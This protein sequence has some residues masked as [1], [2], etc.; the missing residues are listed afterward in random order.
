MPIVTNSPSNQPL[1]PK[2]FLTPT[3]RSVAVSN[4]PGMQ[5]QRIAE[6]LRSAAVE[7]NIAMTLLPGLLVASG[8][9]ECDTLVLEGVD[10]QVLYGISISDPACPLEEGQLGVGLGNVVT[11]RLEPTRIGPMI[12]GEYR[13]ISLEGDAFFKVVAAVVKDCDPQQITNLE[14]SDLRNELADRVLLDDPLMSRIWA[15]AHPSVEDTAN[16]VSMLWRGGVVAATAAT[17]GVFGS[18]APMLLGAWYLGLPLA[19]TLHLAEQG[20]RESREHL[21]LHLARQLPGLD[22]SHLDILLRK[23]H[24][25]MAELD[26]ETV[27]VNLKRMFEEREPWQT[28]TDLLEH[29]RPADWLRAVRTNK[30]RQPVLTP[31][32][33]LLGGAIELAVYLNVPGL[34]PGQMYKAGSVPPIPPD[35]QLTF[36]ESEVKPSSAAPTAEEVAPTSSTSVDFMLPVVAAVV[37]AQGPSGGWGSGL[38]AGMLLV[39]SSVQAAPVGQ[40][41]LANI[42]AVQESVAEQ[43]TE[44]SRLKAQRR[45]LV[46]QK[47]VYEAALQKATGEL[48]LPPGSYPGF[49]SEKHYY[50]LLIRGNYQ[51]R[52]AM[53]FKIST[54]QDR[55][56]VLK[57]ALTQAINAADDVDRPSLTSSA[58]PSSPALGSDEYVDEV[59]LNQLRIHNNSGLAFDRKVLDEQVSVK[60]ATKG[61]SFSNAF[62]GDLTRYSVRDILLGKH[63]RCG[64]VVANV[65]PGDRLKHH[66][67]AAFLRR[68]EFAGYVAKQF[69][70]DTAALKKDPLYGEQYEHVARQRFQGVL[71]KYL[72][73]GASGHVRYLINQWMLGQT[74]ERLV[75]VNGKVVPHLLALWATAG[76]MLVSTATGKVYLWPEYDQSTE[77]ERFIR[78]HLSHVDQQ[79]IK[80]EDIIAQRSSIKDAQ[81]WTAKISFE[82]RHNPYARLFTAEMDWLDSN[83]NGYVFTADE[84]RQ[85]AEINLERGLMQ[86]GATVATLALTLGAGGELLPLVIALGVD[87]AT[88]VAS[89][90]LDY[91][92]LEVADSADLIREAEADISADRL[93]LIL[94]GASAGM[95]AVRPFMESVEMVGALT[96]DMKQIVRLFRQQLQSQNGER[97]SLAAF[98]RASPRERSIMMAE[99]GF[100][101]A[102]GQH[103]PAWQQVMHVQSRAGIPAS[104]SV[105]GSMAPD[106]RV[107]FLGR[108]AKQIFTAEDL[109]ALPRG[110]RVAVVA[111]SDGELLHGSVSL[112]NGKVTGLAQQTL[113]AKTSARPWTAVDLK[114]QLKFGPDGIHCNGAGVLVYVDASAPE[115]RGEPLLAPVRT[116]LNN[117]E[118]LAQQAYLAD[119]WA[120]NLPGEIDACQRSLEYMETH[121]FSDAKVRVMSAWRNDRMILHYLA[122][123]TDAKGQRVVFD[124]KPA[125]S[126]LWRSEVLDTSMVLPENVW[127]GTYQTEARG[128]TVKYREF[129]SLTDAKSYAVQAQALSPVEFQQGAVLVNAPQ[130]YRRLTGRGLQA[131]ATALTSSSADDTRYDQELNKW[132][133]ASAG[134]SAEYALGKKKPTVVPGLPVDTQRWSSARLKAWYLKFADK[135]SDREKG[136][137]AARIEQSSYAES[138]MKNLLRAGNRFKYFSVQGNAVYRAVPQ[139]LVIG[140]G[141]GK[142]LGLVKAMAVALD[143]GT[144]NNLVDRLFFYAANTGAAE[145]KLLKQ[146]L[147]VLNK[148]SLHSRTGAHF[149]LSDVFDRLKALTATRYYELGTRNHAMLIGARISNGRAVYHFYDPNTGLVEFERFSDFEALLK[150][151]FSDRKLNKVYRVYGTAKAPRFEL[152]SIDIAIESKFRLN[153]RLTTADLGSETPLDLAKG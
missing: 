48:P 73:N 78:Y 123:G 24:G 131:K 89:L 45:Q 55:I 145:S 13:A 96:A 65:N 36:V 50:R 44:I 102:A 100:E 112:G 79:L 119:L 84:Q 104:V 54:L 98:F 140:T 80:S 107:V 92:L 109:E 59:L 8:V 19:A 58:A 35:R 139:A 28:A 17:F 91:E 101:P 81:Y 150:H 120:E 12:R 34:V 147:A 127:I 142:C 67:V 22:D 115:F 111:Q 20:P 51:Q 149:P 138:V 74:H 64:K 71:A 144:Q 130:I 21:L 52:I 117:A 76:A 133:T 116:A 61:F 30:R 87:V 16:P 3:P 4:P 5:S 15:Q 27:T 46:E 47:A 70:A 6:A 37:A 9:L 137:L 14:V 49:I 66:P 62:V 83:L 38:M 32:R 106:W 72:L 25:L 93:M 152:N 41:P 105:Q 26:L 143:A 114:E 10:G 77:F 110:Y 132:R 11:I 146:S 42:V 126:G 63:Y 40:R 1:I 7:E 151:Y 94:S 31:P 125:A 69:S 128:W 18:F 2:E 129:D 82:Q 90:H 124:L 95:Q 75:L 57:G 121:G 68:R 108:E 88:G 43:E 141:E 118:T 56:R 60:F 135:L 85:A 113:F 86:F 136:A 39:G 148:G 122:V 29:L 103:R 99:L 134:R 53:Q 23:L 153:S 33:R 97:L